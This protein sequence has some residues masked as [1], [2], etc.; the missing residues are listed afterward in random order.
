MCSMRSYQLNILIDIVGLLVCFWIC[1]F[2]CLPRGM[3]DWAAI[4][5]VVQYQADPWRRRSKP[6][7]LRRCSKNQF[8]IEVPMVGD[9]SDIKLIRTDTTL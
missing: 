5:E 6:L 2:Y 7:A 8:N 4:L 1:F 3:G 9:V